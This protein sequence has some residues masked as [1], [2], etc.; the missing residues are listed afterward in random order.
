M[1]DE[2]DSVKRML[3][4]KTRQ[5]EYQRLD[6]EP[7]V[8]GQPLLH[9]EFGFPKVGSEKRRNIPSTREISGEPVVVKAS[10][11]TSTNPTKP[12]FRKQIKKSAD[13]D[14]KFIPPKNNFVSVGNVEHAWYDDKVTGI[15]DNNEEVDIE[16]LQGINP[17]ADMKNPKTAESIKFFTKRLQHVKSLVVAELSEITDLQ[18]LKNLRENTFGPKGIFTDIV[19]QLDTLKVDKVVIGELVSNM[20]SEL[21]LEIGGKEFE[22]TSEAEEDSQITEWPEEMAQIVRPPPDEDDD[23]DEEEVQEEDQSDSEEVAA[24]PACPAAIPEGHYAV[25]VDG[26]LVNIE[27]DAGTVRDFISDLLLNENLEID[28]IQLIK[29][30]KI[31]FG[32]ILGE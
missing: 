14:D 15:I 21:D 32:I 4:A 28:R 29:R 11:A 24:E 7:K 18:E 27:E 6:I 2:K 22:L 31:D 20:Y 23:E 10:P 8:G 1:T 19:K 9:D 13:D 25:I 30:I 3:E 16:K 5:P 26:K 17:L 12:T